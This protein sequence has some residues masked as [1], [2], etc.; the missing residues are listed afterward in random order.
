MKR[1]HWLIS[2][3][4]AV[5]ALCTA[6][7]APAQPPPHP[8]YVRAILQL[9]LMRAYLNRQTPS[10]QLDNE[11]VAAMSEIDS[12]MGEIFDASIEDGHDPHW[13][14]SIEGHLRRGD[15]FRRARDAGA[16]AFNEVN[17]VEDNGFANGLKRRALVHIERANRM[18]DHLIHQTGGM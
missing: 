13:V 12:A 14:P 7:P 16:V 3:G 5:L 4:T 18:V 10:E 15:R 9:R 17:Q 1:K 8:H 11:Q 6:A 2:L